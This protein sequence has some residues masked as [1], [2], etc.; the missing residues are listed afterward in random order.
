MFTRSK[1]SATNIHRLRPPVKKKQITVPCVNFVLKFYCLYKMTRST[2]LEQLTPS[3]SKSEREQVESS[4]QQHHSTPASS[5]VFEDVDR[6]LEQDED[7]DIETILNDKH[8]RSMKKT[9]VSMTEDANSN[10]VRSLQQQI[11]SLKSE[12]LKNQPMNKSDGTTT[13][14]TGGLINKDNLFLMFKHLNAVEWKT[15]GLMFVITMLV[16]SD[17]SHE[18]LLNVFQKCKYIDIGYLFLI[19]SFMVCVLMLIGSFIL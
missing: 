19:K 14:S 6:A 3:V 17:R 11:E 12:L 16:Y 7:F 13:E 9:T 5:H 8:I 15:Y 4:Q 18:T 2:S 10:S 1:M